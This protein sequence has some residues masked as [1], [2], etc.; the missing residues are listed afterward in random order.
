MA[1]GLSQYRPTWD[2]TRATCGGD[3]V[4]EDDEIL[5]ATDFECGNGQNIRRLDAA[6]YALDLE[7]EPG[8]HRFSGKSYYF[9]F[10][11]RNKR[12]EART[13]VM[14]LRNHGLPQW[15]EQTQHVVTRRG[16]VWGQA[17]RDAIRGFPPAE[18]APDDPAAHLDLRLDLPSC[19]DEAPVTFYSNFHWYP[20]T[21]LVRDL[22][23]LAANH[24]AIDLST[25]GMSSMGREILCAQVGPRDP[26][27]PHIVMAQTPQPSEMGQWACR[28]VLEWLVSDDPQARACRARHRVS[29]LPNTNPDGTAFGYGVSDGLGRFPYFEADR[30]VDDSPEATPETAAVWRHLKS[31]RPWLFIEW[32]SNN[33]SRR[34]GHMLLRYEHDLMTDARRRSM[35]DAWEEALLQLP[36][37]HH[38]NWTGRDT[39]LYQCSM[40][41]A[42]VTRLN[43]IACMI[44]HHDK[45]EM[46]AILG[47]AVDC[48]KAALQVWDA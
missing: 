21:D 17:P 36:E 14:E 29:F 3:Y 48:F 31:T 25:L 35:W 39:G 46:D 26:D 15:Y 38:G 42:A 5:I 34:P 28:A 13:L 19:Q 23:D 45:Y 10:G 24:D 40:G 1:L 37:T 44:K 9:C 11:V 8:R 41:F 7:P 27:A 6:R 16:D 18:D 20:Y 22:R 32:H 12:P 33:W 4:Y 43:A 47:H 30:A 2:R